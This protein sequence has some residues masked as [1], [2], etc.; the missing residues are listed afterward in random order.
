MAKLIEFD[1]IVSKP[2][3]KSI[4]HKKML[5]KSIDRLIS[6][7]PKHIKKTWIEINYIDDNGKEVCIENLQNKFYL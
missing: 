1:V 3:T 4:E 7:M 5:S 2:V 6:S